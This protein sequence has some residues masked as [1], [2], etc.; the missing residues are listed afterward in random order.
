MA[1]KLFVDV[2][3]VSRGVKWFGFESLLLSR[4][5]VWRSDEAVDWSG[6][7]NVTEERSGSGD[8]GHR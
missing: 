7:Q 2:S 8:V 4:K 1:W 3:K 5:Y 6:G